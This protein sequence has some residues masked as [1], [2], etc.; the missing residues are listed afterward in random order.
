M[1]VDNP[2]SPPISLQWLQKSMRS[3]V[4][5]LGQIQS[6]TVPLFNTLFSCIYFRFI[7]AKSTFF[8]SLKNRVKG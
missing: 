8:P 5:V 4:G 6:D 3:I 2:V 7:V 1:D